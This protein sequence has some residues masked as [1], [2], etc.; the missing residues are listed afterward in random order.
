[1]VVDPVSDDTHW[2]RRKVLTARG[3]DASA[4]QLIEL[5]RAQRFFEALQLQAVEVFRPLASE[6]GE[7]I[8]AI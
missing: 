5:D 8:E 3:L 4:V 6:R 2:S 1:M 7:E